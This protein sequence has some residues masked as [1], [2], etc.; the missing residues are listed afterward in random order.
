MKSGFFFILV[1]LVLT[2]CAA[3]Q[4]PPLLLHTVEL[5]PWSSPTPAPTQP[6]PE[7]ERIDVVAPP[8]P[9]PRT[10]II[11]KGE[12]LGGLALRYGV[13]LS[14]ILAANPEID[15]RMISIGTAIIIPSRT[16]E[17][18]APV[19]QASEA[20]VS[21]SAPRCLLNG[22]GGLTCIAA[23]RSDEDAPV[24]NISLNFVLLDG[25]GNEIDSELSFAPLNLL[26]AG[27]SMPL[28]ANFP[29]ALPASFTV[30]ADLS[31]ALPGGNSSGR[32]LNHS[33]EGTSADIAPDGLSARVS[34]QVQLMPDQVDAA[35]L[36]VLAV[37]YNQAG[38]V[39]CFRRWDDAG[40][41]EAGQMR[42][43]EFTLYSSIEKIERV[44]FLSEA[45]P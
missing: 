9:S 12:D 45:R 1:G 6:P 28:L 27:A 5:S 37:G 20:G 14:E 41:L 31:G 43:F 21:I 38:D 17:E 30:R 18:P 3:P 8:T 13:P 34:G 40:D 7:A 33:L 36:W 15:P 29:G 26:P 32:Y 44:E 42:T 2:A 4:E 10:H 39:V 11:E 24:E 35:T 22:G 16:G 19:M 23:V 25:E